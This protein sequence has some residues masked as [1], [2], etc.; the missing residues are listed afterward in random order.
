MMST[1]VAIR[2]ATLA[3]AAM[4]AVPAAQAAVPPI[5]AFPKIFIND[6][7]QSTTHRPVIQ[8]QAITLHNSAVTVTCEIV[9]MEQAFNETAEGTERGFLNT[10]GYSTY[11]CKSEGPCKVKN[12]KGEE[13]EGIYL[14]AESP[15]IAEGTEAHLTGISSLPWTG[16]FIER[17]E[18]LKQVLMKHVK[19]WVVFPPPSVGTGPGCVGTE[20]EFEEAE[21]KTEKEEGYELA[22]L[23]INGA[24]TTPLKPSH[25]EF[26]EREGETE[27][28]F[29][30]TGRLRSPQVGDGFLRA[31]KLV[32]GGM[33]GAW[34]LVTAESVGPPPTV[35]N[36][37]P[38]S[39]PTAGGTSVTITG[40]AL[41]GTLN[42]R[43]RFGTKIVPINSGSATSI[44]AVSP[45][46]EGTVD[47]TVE[48]GAG[49]SP[50]VEA[51]K[52]TYK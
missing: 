41:E 38:N 52:F 12:T 50:I 8:V 45:P 34:E 30:I 46:G 5:K 25:S 29:P 32:A 19:L 28:G 15:P 10:L 36:V 11:E 40:T 51:D 4:I 33:G 42:T 20:I 9:Q 18:G 37:K 16:E 21:G 35:T 1:R 6:T 13:V 44:T 31:T 39:G 3:V 24:H 47:V 17:E 7:K 22:P 14:T 43:V 48:T 27:K 49:L 23:W 2:A 26:I